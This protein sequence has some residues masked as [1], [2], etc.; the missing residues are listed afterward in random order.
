L[1]QAEILLNWLQRVWHEPAVS[2]RVILRRGPKPI[3]DKA[4]AERLLAILESHGWLWA[5]E[6]AT[7]EGKPARKAWGI[8]GKGL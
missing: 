7:V 1:R 4:T 8:Y 6:E 5:M 3:R 2:V